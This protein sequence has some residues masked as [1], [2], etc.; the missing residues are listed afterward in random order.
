LLV[1][2]KKVKKT[3]FYSDPFDEPASTI[4]IVDKEISKV[5]FISLILLSPPV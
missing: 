1:F 2:T 3:R 5:S 4:E